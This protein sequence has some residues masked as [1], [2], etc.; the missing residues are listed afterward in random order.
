MDYIIASVA[1]TDEIHFPDGTSMNQLAG[2]AGIYALAGIKIWTDQVQLATGVGQDYESLFGDWYEKNGVSME[3]LMI[4]DNKTP[5][6]LINYFENGE[7]QETSLYGNDHFLKIEVTPEEL[8]PY[9]GEAKGIYIFKNA[10]KIFWDKILGYRKESNTKIMWEISNE[11]TDFEKLDLVKEIATQIDIFSIN[12]TEAFTLLNVETVEEV[13][14]E[15]KTW[16]VPLIFFRQGSLGAYMISGQEVILAQSIKGTPVV[17][18][19]GGGNSS[20]GAV[21]YGF[22]EQESP[23]IAGIM[24]SVS[25]AICIGQYGVP[26][27]MDQEL[28]NKAHTMLT[29]LKEE[30]E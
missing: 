16:K 7:R 21:L 5:H 6:T 18:S 28:R 22:C 30:E 17:D 15:F 12:K 25:A 13:I 9:F 11:A 3:G 23:Y 24:G 4:K 20:S 14:E 2:G 27:I 29:K 8:K 26:E 1:V 19:T 10:D